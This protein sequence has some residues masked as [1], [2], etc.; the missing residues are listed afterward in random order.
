MT[1]YARKRSTGMTVRLGVLVP[2]TAPAETGAAMA[3]APVTAYD[4]TLATRRLPS[5]ADPDKVEA[6]AERAAIAAAERAAATGRAYGTPVKGYRSRK[7][8]TWPGYSPIGSG[9]FTGD[10]GAAPKDRMGR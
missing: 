2:V 1:F 9:P 3:A 5:T 7:G 8:R 10:A 4:R 6:R